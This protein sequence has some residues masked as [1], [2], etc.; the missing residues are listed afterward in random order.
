MR[1]CAP[2]QVP[3]GAGSPT[4]CQL[5]RS[6]TGDAEG[7]RTP[8]GSC[9]PQAMKPEPEPE[10]EPKPEPETETE[11]EPERLELEPEPEPEPERLEPERERLEP[12]PEREPEPEP[13]PEPERERERLEPEPE[14]GATVAAAIE[15]RAARL[16]NLISAGAQQLGQHAKEGAATYKRTTARLE[17]EQVDPKALERLAA[18]REVS[19][20]GLAATQTALSG[21]SSGIKAASSTLSRAMRARKARPG[22]TQPQ[23]KPSA[24]TSASGS[25]AKEIAGA[26]AS[27]VVEVY[28]SLRAAASSVSTDVAEATVDAVTHR[29]GEQ[30]GISTRDGLQTFDNIGRAVFNV[31]QITASALDVV[32]ELACA[33]ESEWLKGD[34]IMEGRW[35]FHIVGTFGRAQTQQAPRSRMCRVRLLPASLVID[36][37]SPRETEPVGGEEDPSVRA[38]EEHG[39]STET[40]N[41]SANPPHRAADDGVAA[42]RNEKHGEEEDHLSTERGLPSVP[43]RRFIPLDDVRCCLGGR[44]STQSGDVA[45]AQAITDR[46][47]QRWQ[48]PLL[49]AGEMF[50]VVSRDDITYRFQSASDLDMLLERQSPQQSLSEQQIGEGRDEKLKQHVNGVPNSVDISAL[51]EWVDAINAAA[52]DRRKVWEGKGK[53]EGVK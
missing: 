20:T 53:N 11:T 22:S 29:Y 23:Q 26:G 5:H 49:A 41:E 38:S 12:E 40:C 45:R 36:L 28:H 31:G 42:N 15:R 33:R 18:A 52:T 7:A 13:E 48:H 43:L 50:E 25:A 24:P 39:A 6:Y 14:P 10:L 51:Q 37:P 46:D 8:A 21:V 19:A 2:P 17:P 27:A 47:R 3:R 4:D 44:F 32:G 35:L 30:A 9:V 1:R 16:T 34:I